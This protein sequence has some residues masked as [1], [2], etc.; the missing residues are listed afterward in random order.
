MEVRVP[1]LYTSRC[2]TFIL[3]II[4]ENHL[5]RKPVPLFHACSRTEASPVFV[6]LFTV[7]KDV[8]KQLGY[9]NTHIQCC[10][11]D[12]CKESLN[13][14]LDVEPSATPVDCNIHVLRG[15]ARNKYRLVDKLYLN[16]ALS[17]VKVNVYYVLYEYTL[18]QYRCCV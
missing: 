7:V 10:G 17:N 13:G 11:M 3:F 18:P 12:H 14:L 15:M 2:N 4:T 16:T 5:S 6:A 8:A 9:P 1:L